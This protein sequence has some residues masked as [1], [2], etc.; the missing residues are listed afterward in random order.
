MPSFERLMKMQPIRGDRFPLVNLPKDR[1]LRGVYLLTEGECHLYV[2]RSN[3]IIGRYYAHRRESSGDGVAPFAFR[4]ACLS[5][6]RTAISNVKGHPETRAM[7]M[8]D[9]EYRAHFSAAKTRI[10]KMDFRYVVESDPVN[11]AILEVY[12]AAALGTPHNT[13]DNH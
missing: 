8:L 7:K 11:Q 2:G 3:D 12:C 6:D 10:R 13:F 5:S 4:L 9:L 1:R